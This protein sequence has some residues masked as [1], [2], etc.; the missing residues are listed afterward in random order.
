MTTMLGNTATEI[1]LGFSIAL[2]R[3]ETKVEKGLV[4]I[5]EKIFDA[6]GKPIEGYQVERIGK[7]TVTLYLN[8]VAISL[9]DIH[10]KWEEKIRA[11]TG[12]TRVPNCFHVLTPRG[13]DEQSILTYKQLF[14]RMDWLISTCKQLEEFF[15]EVFD[16]KIEISS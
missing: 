13:M 2:D 1:S 5:A 11:V 7:A 14:Y 4:K 12:E 9:E 16:V 15:L 10:K 6:Q 8:D 3:V